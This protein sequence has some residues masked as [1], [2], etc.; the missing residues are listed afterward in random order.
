MSF[1]IMPLQT[2]THIQVRISTHDRFLHVHACFR[3]I[4][5]NDTGIKTQTRS[6]PSLHFTI[7]V[8]STTSTFCLSLCCRSYKS[9]SIYRVVCLMPSRQ[10]IFKWKPGYCVKETVVQ[11]L[12]R[13]V[14]AFVT[15]FSEKP[16]V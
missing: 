12:S 14:T 7:N 11:P 2:V 13:L 8:S 1:R 4:S 10:L 9:A 3:S 16:Q 6:T 15:L 5:L